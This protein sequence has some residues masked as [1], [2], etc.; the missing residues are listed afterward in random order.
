MQQGIAAKVIAACLGLA[1]FA[2]AIIAGLAGGNDTGTILVGA[3][4]AL[5]ACQ[6]VGMCIGMAAEVV[7]R[8]HIASLA[9]SRSTGAGAAGAPA[10]PHEVL[11]NPST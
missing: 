10:S 8:E 5:F 11:P 7:V 1:G 4:V 9:K 6:L 3:V 2:V